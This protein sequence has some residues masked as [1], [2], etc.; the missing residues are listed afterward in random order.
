VTVTCLWA[1]GPTAS[2][3]FARPCSC[4]WSCSTTTRATK[5]R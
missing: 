3:E 4:R 2:L 1:V 5:A